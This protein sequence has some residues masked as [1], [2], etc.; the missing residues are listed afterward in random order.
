MNSPILQHDADRPFDLSN[1]AP[2]RSLR[3]LIEGCGSVMNSRVRERAVD[4]VVR[5]ELAG[6]TI[7]TTPTHVHGVP[8]APSLLQQARAA[9]QAEPDIQLGS[10]TQ[11]QP[12][13]CGS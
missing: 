8:A 7:S 4:R 13:A 10:A 11:P 9:R 6:F 1:P 3:A 5:I 2:A 12:S